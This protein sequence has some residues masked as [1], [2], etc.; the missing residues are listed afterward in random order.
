MSFKRVEI[1]VAGQ[2]QGVSLRANTWNEARR[3]GL[4]GYVGN[5]NDGSVEI[6]AEGEEEN[7]KRILSWVKGSPGF[8]QIEEIKFF[9][10]KPSGEFSDFQIK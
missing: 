5:L 3:L 1:K 6:I 4:V 7:L 10:Q 2:V 9:W 8:A